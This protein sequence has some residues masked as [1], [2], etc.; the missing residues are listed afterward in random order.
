METNPSNASISEPKKAFLTK[1]SEYNVSIIFL[2]DEALSLNN[3]ESGLLRFSVNTS[4]PVTVKEPRNNCSMAGDR[5]R[6]WSKNKFQKHYIIVKLLRIN[7]F[8]EL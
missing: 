1:L 5:L 6:N 2:Y 7:D 8:Y 4:P 3:M